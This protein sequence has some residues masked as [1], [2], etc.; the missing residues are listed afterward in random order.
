MTTYINWIKAL[1]IASAL[2]V[3]SGCGGGESNNNGSEFNPTHTLD[4]N[5]GSWSLDNNAT[6]EIPPDSVLGLTNVDFNKTEKPKDSGEEAL[7]YQFSSDKEIEYASFKLPINFT[8]INDKD[9]LDLIY[10]RDEDGAYNILDF[11]YNRNQ[12]TIT[13]NIKNNWTFNNIPE[14]IQGSILPSAVNSNKTIS[15]HSSIWILKK[16]LYRLD[17]FPDIKMPMPMPFFAQM[18][19]TCWA[20]S[21]QMLEHS[22]YNAGLAPGNQIYDYMKFLDVNS[23]QGIVTDEHFRRFSTFIA[24]NKGQARTSAYYSTTNVKYKILELLNQN[25][26]VLFA[27]GIHQ[28]LIVGY[29]KTSDDVEL[30]QHNPSYP[31][32]ADGRG[33]YEKMEFYDSFYTEDQ[34]RKDPSLKFKKP[35]VKVSKLT[36]VEAELNPERSLQTV[37]IPETGTQYDIYFYGRKTNE[38]MKIGLDYNNTAI[39]GYRWKKTAGVGDRVYTGG[40]FPE[41]INKFVLDLPV[42]NADMDNNADLT[43]DVKIYE[44]DNPDNEVKKSYS[45]LLPPKGYI[46]KRFIMD[47]KPILENINKESDFIVKI[48]LQKDTKLLFDTEIKRVVLQPLKGCINGIK[49]NWIDN[50]LGVISDPTIQEIN[51]ANISVSGSVDKLSIS[52]KP[53]LDAYWLAVE[54]T[55]KSKAIYGINGKLNGKG[56]RYSF[57]PPVQYGDY[58]IVN[59]GGFGQ[60]S[61]PPL[62]SD[63]SVFNIYHVEVHHG[64]KGSGYTHSSELSF[65]FCQ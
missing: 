24:G 35:W 63:D 62:T 34:F 38:S 9:D 46:V 21:G 57:A 52:W 54:Q 3:M 49:V 32:P 22:L 41:Y 30:I 27:R 12:Q 25:H 14:N 51:N 37:T 1:L 17:S 64:S 33:M 18:G 5:G 19:P 8:D 20:A 48:M 13:F 53:P 44:K 50:G 40:S 55:G 16:N 36:W 4:E 45:F 6:I 58:S 23:T 2:I 65:S 42:W 15:R 59:T 39:D 47:L 11:Q 43:L 60:N 26:Q 61:S 7:V 29:I 31:D 28:V 56:G 10:V